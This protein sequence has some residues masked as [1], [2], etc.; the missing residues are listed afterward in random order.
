[1][2]GARALFLNV[3]DRCNPESGDE[4][5]PEGWAVDLHCRRSGPLG[6]LLAALLPPGPG[7]SLRLRQ[8][9]LTCYELR[10]GQLECDGRLAALQVLQLSQCGWPG[11]ID[12]AL[13]ALLQ[14]AP[15]LCRLEI[16]DCPALRAPPPCL[17]GRTGVRALI[18]V[19]CPL[20]ELPPG[21]YLQGGWCWGRGAL[22]GAEQAHGALA[23]KRRGCPPKRRNL[24]LTTCAS[25][26][27]HPVRLA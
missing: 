19:Q 7:C 4:P 13:A 24:G 2:G 23:G 12:V 10:P 26:V 22:A 16:T 20:T 27:P 25:P 5:A 3:S 15:R 21:P 18:L 14:Q 17:V 1:M 6:P 8:L 11:G 9:A